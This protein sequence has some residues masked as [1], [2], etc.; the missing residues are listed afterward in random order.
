MD[1]KLKDSILK[2]SIRFPYD[3]LWRKKYNVAFNS[4]DHRE[5]NFIDQ[6]FDII[7]DEVF[8]QLINKSVYTPNQN[9][10]LN[11]REIKNKS[12]DQEIEDFNK[13]YGE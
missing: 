2:W 5:S 12:F 6:V 13:Q 7:E 9:D 11:K 3:R 4:P 8:E 10:F 1:E